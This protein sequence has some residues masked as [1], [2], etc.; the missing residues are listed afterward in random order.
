MAMIRKVFEGGVLE[1]FFNKTLIVLIPK[2][3]TQETM[4]QLHP[5]S[6]CTVPYMLLTKVIVNRHKFSMPI[7]VA[8]NQTSFVSGRNIMD[9]VVVAQEVIHSM[10][11]RK[12]KKG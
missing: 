3:S 6:L 8:E 11:N 12:G 10:R 2:V 1:G 9:N 4:F 5:I 7:L